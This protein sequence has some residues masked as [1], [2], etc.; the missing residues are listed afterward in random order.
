[1]IKLK[2]PKSLIYH[3]FQVCEVDPCDLESTHIWTDSE[4]RI[5]DICEKH[6]KQLQAQR[7]IS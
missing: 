1:M 7:Y 4:I 6:Y 3:A 2:D 5:I